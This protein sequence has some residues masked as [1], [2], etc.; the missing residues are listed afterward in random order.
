[1]VC[2]GNKPGL[3]L[4]NERIFHV[5]SSRSNGNSNLTLGDY[6]ALGTMLPRDADSVKMQ[7]RGLLDVLKRFLRPNTA[8]AGSAGGGTPD[9]L[10]AR[11]NMDDFVTALL[12][13]REIRDLNPGQEIQ[14][15]SNFFADMLQI[16][17]GI[18]R[19]DVTGDQMA[20]R[21]APGVTPEQA[22]KLA[23]LVG[24]SLDDLE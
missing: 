14:A 21:D 18:L 1:M 6:I 19:R 20:T 23:M 12:S 17:R 24:R 22:L 9:P 10:A 2:H 3:I 4:E 5:P 15:R 11:D 7:A 13:H 8:Q 16:L